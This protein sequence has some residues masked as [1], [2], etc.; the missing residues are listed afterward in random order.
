MTNALLHALNTSTNSGMVGISIGLCIAISSVSAIV[1]PACP[2]LHPNRGN[3]PGSFHRSLAAF[4]HSHSG[5]RQP[6]DRTC[7]LLLGSKSHTSQSGVSDTRLGVDSRSSPVP[8]F[9]FISVVGG[10]VGG[11]V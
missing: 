5:H 8:H 3:Q 6:A 11:V 4:L 9:A 2:A 7:T 1:R 10:V